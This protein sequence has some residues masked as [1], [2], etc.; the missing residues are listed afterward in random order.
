MRKATI[1]CVDASCNDAKYCGN[2]SYANGTSTSAGKKD[3]KS[4]SEE[5]WD[6]ADRAKQQDLK[7]Q[8]EFVE[9]LIKKEKESTRQI[10]SKSEK[11][12]H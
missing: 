7:E 12:V 2:F 6:K 4:S 8:R 3:N 10:V 9:R 11:K 1:Y 5:E